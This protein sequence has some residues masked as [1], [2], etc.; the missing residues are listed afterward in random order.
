MPASKLGLATRAFV[1]V[2]LALARQYELLLQVNRDSPA[3]ELVKFGFG[4]L[5][6]SPVCFASGVLEK[7]SWRQHPEITRS[8]D[9][10]FIKNSLI[11]NLPFPSLD[12]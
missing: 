1:A 6:L 3:Q 7:I 4:L 10:S 8:H 9:T 12:S 2:L 5:K 11:Q